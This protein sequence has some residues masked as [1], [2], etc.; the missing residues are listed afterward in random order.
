MVNLNA[1]V[2][3][4]SGMGIYLLSDFAVSLPVLFQLTGFRADDL[5]SVCPS[6][7]SGAISRDSAIS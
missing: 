6:L 4:R 3:V 5:G 7:N 1:T 2:T